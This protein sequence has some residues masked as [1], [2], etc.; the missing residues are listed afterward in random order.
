MNPS[1]ILK[2]SKEPVLTHKQGF[3]KTIKKTTEPVEEPYPELLSLAKIQKPKTRGYLNSQMF[4]NPETK[5]FFDCN[6]FQNF[7]EQNFQKPP[8][9][10]L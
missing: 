3:Q 6:I 1:P 5:R 10:C 2:K 9:S 8:N 4:Q 7:K